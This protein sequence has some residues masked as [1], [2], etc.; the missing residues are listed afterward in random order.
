LLLFVPALRGQTQGNLNFL[1]DLSD[2]QNLRRMLPEFL[3][4]QARALLQQRRALVDRISNDQDVKARKAYIRERML[5]ALGEFPKKT[6]LNVQ[7][8]GR[9]NLQPVRIARKAKDVRG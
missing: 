7:S 9:E 5:S 2:F 3:K 1:T 6:P 4:S 8:V